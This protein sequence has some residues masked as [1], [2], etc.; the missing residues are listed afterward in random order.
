MLTRNPTD[1]RFDAAPVYNSRN[2]RMLPSLR[3]R[4]ACC[5]ITVCAFSAIAQAT[6]WCPLIAQLSAKIAAATGPAVI[7]LDI[8]NRSSVSAP[9]VEALGRE[10]TS[11]LRSSGACVCEPARAAGTL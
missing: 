5:V 11:S 7:A 10:S 2:L 3:V 4:L 1:H 6:D 8:T 9:D